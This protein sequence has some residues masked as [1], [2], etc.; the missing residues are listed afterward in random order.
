MIEKLW[1]GGV[2]YDFLIHFWDEGVLSNATDHPWLNPQVQF[3]DFLSE[4]EIFMT[5]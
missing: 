3:V 5:V 4:F 1:V 2:F